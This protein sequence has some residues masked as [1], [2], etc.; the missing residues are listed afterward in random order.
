VLN[1]RAP[2]RRGP[3]ETTTIKYGLPAALAALALIAPAAVEAQP[4]AAP[5]V[6]SGMMANPMATGA[7]ATGTIAGQPQPGAGEFA[8]YNGTDQFGVAPMAPEMAQPTPVPPGAVWITGHPNSQNYVWLA[9]EYAQPPHPGAQWVGGH[10]EQTP[11]AWVWVDG[12]W[13]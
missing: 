7:S 5:P 11:R 4:Y 6:P 2:Q 10:W 1:L 12:R 9:G 3:K 13:S 8:D